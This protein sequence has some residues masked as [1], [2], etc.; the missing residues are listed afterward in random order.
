MALAAGIVEE[1]VDVELL[2]L[3]DVP[4]LAAL[5]LSVLLVS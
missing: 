1:R 5:V 2:Q 3:L 4:K